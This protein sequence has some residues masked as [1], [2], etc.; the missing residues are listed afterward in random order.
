MRPDVTVL[1]RQHL[2]DTQRTSRMLRRSGVD[3]QLDKAQP[4]ASVLAAGR[5]VVW[6]LGTDA[7]P[8]LTV[9]L[10][11][12]K[13]GAPTID[14]EN[15]HADLDSAL[16]DLRVLFSE[17]RSG[18]PIAD[19]HHAH[20]LTTLARIAYGRSLLGWAAALL[21]RAL[22][23]APRHVE[24]LVNRGVVHGRTQN[25][26]LA[27]AVTERALTIEPNRPLALTNA[28]RYRMRLAD[29]DAARVHAE[30]ATRVAS[31]NAASWAIAGVLDARDGNF[32]RARER[33]ERALSID[34]NEADA[35][36]ALAQLDSK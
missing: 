24:A 25:W 11:L 26:Q 30:R 4:L 22:E 31:T 8:P 23:L 27:V 3:V 5:P 16:A 36:A 2:L 10:P 20:S 35:R 9:G 18:D 13:V 29:Y 17:N 19:A 1:V 14:S 21:D 33:L 7:H 28:A 34:P 15:P 6:E 12:A 32:E